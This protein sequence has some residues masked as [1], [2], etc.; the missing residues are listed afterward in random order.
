ML[1]SIKD[2][3]NRCPNDGNIYLVHELSDNSGFFVANNHILYMVLNFEQARHQ[4]LSTEYLKLNTNVDIFSIKNNQRF[5]SGKYNILELLPIENRYDDAT[6]DSFI[7][8]CMAHSEYMDG[9][10]FVR[11]FYSLTNIFQMPKEQQ[12]KNLIGLFGELSFIKMLCEKHGIDLSNYWHKGGSKDKYEFALERLNIEIKTTASSDE[13]VT[14]KHA[15]IF[16][17]DNNYLVVICIEENN[18]GLT[19]NE[20]ISK[21]QNDNLHYNN[22]NFAI[23]IEKE[24]KR[25]S[26]VDSDTKKFAVKTISIYAADDINPFTEIPENISGVTYKMDLSEK[27][28][29][30]EKDW[31]QLFE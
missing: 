21:M 13:E 23:N 16:N 25:V 5:P 20:L 6:L 26:P 8:L 27:I 12:Y 19:L 15:Q 17:D 4:N 9:K 10:S 28:I 24:K 7:R 30:P 22:Y 1:N 2:S 18:A 3:L 31:K 11:F 29:I 14:I